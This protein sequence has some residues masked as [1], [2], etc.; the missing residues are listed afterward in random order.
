MG[1]YFP[2]S[3]KVADR[4]RATFSRSIASG[5]AST[6]N[7][8]VRRLQLASG[9]SV[10]LSMVPPMLDV[11]RSSQSRSQLSKIYANLNRVPSSQL[12]AHFSDIMTSD[13]SGC[14]TVGSRVQGHDLGD[15]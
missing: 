13:S 15:P 7:A 3:L 2:K 10:A 11:R 14:G 9:N 12:P 6:F 8:T 1:N 5:V 4:L